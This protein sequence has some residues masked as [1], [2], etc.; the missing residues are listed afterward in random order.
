MA[1]AFGTCPLRGDL[2]LDHGRRRRRDRHPRRR[3]RRP[4][5][6]LRCRRAPRCASSTRT[7][8]ACAHRGSASPAATC[9]RLVG[10]GLARDRSP[11]ARH[12]GRARPP[13]RRRLHRQPQRPQPQQPL[14][15]RVLLKAPADA[16]PLQRQRGSTSTPEQDGLGAHVRQQGDGRGARRRPHRSPA[17]PRGQPAGLQRRP[18]H[19]RRHARRLRAIRARGGKVVVID[20]GARGPRARPTSTI[21]SAGADALPV[22]A[23]VHALFDESLADLRALVG[24][25][26]G[27]TRSVR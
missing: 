21:S 6:R 27:S 5:P 22:L 23:L 16:Q 14:S 12:P 18:A 10:R 25:W 13:G 1:L 11:A 20:R 4:Q 3:R 19:A 15:G 9:A 26:P 17:H 24:T 7:P 8:T 2:R